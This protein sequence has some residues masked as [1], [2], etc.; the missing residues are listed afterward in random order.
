[1][2][3]SAYPVTMLL[4]AANIIIS[5][6]GFY[7]R[8]F[9]NKGIMW[10]YGIKRNGQYYRLISSGFLH[11]DWMHLIFN[12]FTFFFFGQ[13]LEIIFR[14]ALPMGEVW[15]LLLYFTAMIVADIPSYVKHQNDSSYRSLG[16]SGAVS[17]VVFA[18]IIFNPWG[19]LQLYGI[20]SLASTVFAI[21]YIVFTIYMSKQNADNINHDAHLWGAIYGWIFTIIVILI[22]RAD[23]FPYI[24]EELKNPSITGRRTLGP[25]LEYLMK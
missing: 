20:I 6:I 18:A 10:P 4:M 22:F 9:M 11:A 19:Q 13:N 2:D 21:L 25:V 12:M 5:L 16:A 3:F 17:A 15:Y 1:M 14:E 7:N 8:D 24:L 23:I